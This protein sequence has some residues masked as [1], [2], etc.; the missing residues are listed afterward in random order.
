[1]IWLVAHPLHQYK[2]DVKQLAIDAKLQIVDGRFKELIDENE[3]AKDTPK[4]TKKK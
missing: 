3:V 1:M 4:I 2:E